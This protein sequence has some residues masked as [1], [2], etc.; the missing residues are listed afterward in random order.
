MPSIDYNLSRNEAKHLLGNLGSSSCLEYRDLADIIKEFQ[1]IKDRYSTKQKI[2][3][4]YCDGF[5]AKE[6]K[7]DRVELRYE[8]CWNDKSFYIYGF[9]KL[10]D[11]EKA[12]LLAEDAAAKVKQLEYKQKEYERLKRE[13]GQ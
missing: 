8:Y 4:E 3:D 11:A 10:D 6:I 1:E 12:V 2:K 5:D 7:F 13:L 9:R